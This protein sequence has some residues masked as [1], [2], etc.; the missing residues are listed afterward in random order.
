[1][2]SDEAVRRDKTK[3]GLRAPAAPTP[4]ETKF[5]VRTTNDSMHT[6]GERTDG[7]DP[8]KDDLKNDGH[9][10]QDGIPFYLMFFCIL[11]RASGGSSS[12]LHVYNVYVRPAGIT[13]KTDDK[14]GSG[15]RR[16]QGGKRT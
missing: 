8:A 5:M 9:D 3:G 15:S 11:T 10:R 1:M 2:T 13:Q 16:R 7:P 14:T 4:L 6:A 12:R